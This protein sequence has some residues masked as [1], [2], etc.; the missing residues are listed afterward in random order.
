MEPKSLK[1]ADRWHRENMQLYKKLQ[2]RELK[3]DIFQ[4]L[5]E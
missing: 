5:N 4:H 1:D 3:P 2:V